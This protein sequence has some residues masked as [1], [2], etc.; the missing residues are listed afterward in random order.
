MHN[1]ETHLSAA[2]FR[3]ALRLADVCICG[4]GV[5]PFDE[6]ILETAAHLK[7]VACVAGSI[8]GVAIEAM[9]EK[10]VRI[11]S[12]NDVFTQSVAE[13]T[14]DYM[15][16]SLRRLRHCEDVLRQRGWREEAFSNRSF[17]GKKVGI[18]GLGTISNYPIQMLKP[19]RVEITVY[20]G[21]LTQQKAEELGVS[22]GTLEEL[23]QSSD[24]DRRPAAARA[25]LE[26]IRRKQQGIPL[27]NE[28]SHM[29]MRTMTK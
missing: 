21:H 23:S 13:G 17:I 10:G 26:E 1:S 8:N 15:L 2:A 25:V 4:W 16:A 12:G 14:L 3:E 5:H 20:S 19:F 29:H 28:I 22:V 6:E 24:M 7:L 9:Y 27:Q 18:V 11:V